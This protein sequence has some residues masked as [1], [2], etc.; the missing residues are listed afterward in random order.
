MATVTVSLGTR[1]MM[2][3]SAAPARLADRAVTASLTLFMILQFE[4]SKPF[5]PNSES[6]FTALSIGQLYIISKF[7]PAN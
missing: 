1:L 3:A 7:R 4:V 6:L 5:M 2:A